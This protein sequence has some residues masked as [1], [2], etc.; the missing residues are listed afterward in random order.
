MVGSSF[1]NAGGCDEDPREYGSGDSV[2]ED[3]H[4]HMASAQADVWLG[5]QI[6]RH[7]QG[8][9]MPLLNARYPHPRIGHTAAAV[10]RF[11]KRNPIE[12][13]LLDKHNA[14]DKELYTRMNSLFMKR[15]EHV[16]N[17]EEKFLANST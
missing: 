11:R 8:S 6:P 14:L 13:A 10:V 12:G 3:D 15:W 9:S 17:Y 1:Q 4:Q 5:A 16:N 2:T 7:E